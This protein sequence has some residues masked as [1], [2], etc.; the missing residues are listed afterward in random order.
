[1]PYCV[2][3]GVELS[4]SANACPLCN[5]PVILPESMLRDR[6]DG[7]ADALY[8]DRLQRSIRPRL[9]LVTGKPVVLLATFMLA[10]PF[11]ITLLVDIRGNG[12]VTWS[13]YPMMSLVLVWLMLAYPAL[14][15][16]HTIVVAFTVDALA[17][18]AFLISLDYYADGVSGWSWY[19]A[20]ALVLVWLAGLLPVWLAGRPL[21]MAAA[22]FFLL[23]GYLWAME[24]LT[25]SGPWFVPL[26]LPLAGAASLYG[27]GAW[28]VLRLLKAPLPA[29]S[30]IVLLTT[31]LL[32]AAD[33]LIQRFATGRFFLAWS[34]VAAA[35]GVPLSAYL[36]VLH[37][38]SDMR[39]FLQKK[40]HI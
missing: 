29:S 11:L 35:I 34:P 30:A 13:F 31:L 7:K 39:A 38:N 32:L 12:G 27:I 25:K 23:S 15:R 2:K 18:A 6:S 36:W 5:T 16:K 9:N 26:A 17:A 37:G 14:L 3:C 10:I 1:M 4:D 28:A 24:W 19:P 33:V 8:P 20:L 40:F 21:L 22:Y